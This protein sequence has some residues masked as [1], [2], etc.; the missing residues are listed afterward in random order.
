MALEQRLRA[1]SPL[2]VLGRGYSL[3]S[4]EDGAV[5]RSTAGVRV[6]DRVT[7]RLADGGHLDSRVETVRAPREDGAKEDRA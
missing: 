1:L 5:V 7:T 6:G 2:A 3:T 4:T